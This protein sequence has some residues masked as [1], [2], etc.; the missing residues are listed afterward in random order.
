MPPNKS[1]SSSTSRTY[2]PNDNLAKVDAC[3]TIHSLETRTPIADVRLVEFAA[4]IPWTMNL[5]SNDRGGWNGKHLFKDIVARDLGR[6]F[7]HRSKADGHSP[8]ALVCRRLDPQ[9]V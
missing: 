9:R 2:L 5:R 6:D 3:S 8:E 4:T 7:A 1:D